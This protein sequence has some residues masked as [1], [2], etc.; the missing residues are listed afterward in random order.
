MGKI[1]R[2][3]CIYQTE[4]DRFIKIPKHCMGKNNLQHSHTPTRNWYIY[5][6]NIRRYQYTVPP[7]QIDFSE[8]LFVGWIWELHF[9]VAWNCEMIS[10][11]AAWKACF[12]CMK[13]WIKIFTGK[14]TWKHLHSAL[15]TF[16]LLQLISKEPC[17]FFFLGL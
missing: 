16:V 7:P 5:W 12:Y 4:T 17:F 9:F 6:D 8:C 15:N 10:P 13:L 11:H 2:N 3:I 14:K 1:I